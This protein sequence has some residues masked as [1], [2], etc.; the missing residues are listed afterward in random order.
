MTANH[1]Q[2]MAGH[3]ARSA[4]CGRSAGLQARLGVLCHLPFATRHFVSG[5]PGRVPSR[6]PA[7]AV[8]RFKAIQAYSSSFK[9]IQ[10]KKIYASHPLPY[11]LV[12]PQQCEDENKAKADFNLRK[13]LK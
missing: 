9:V 6:G 11:R 10:A 3:D 2:P 12:A 7:S 8:S 5:L 13:P 1:R 4:R